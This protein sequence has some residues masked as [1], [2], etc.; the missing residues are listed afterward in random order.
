LLSGKT[1]SKPTSEK[2]LQELF[3][4]FY[5]RAKTSVKSPGEIVNSAK[6]S[7]GGLGSKLESRRQKLKDMKS[8]AM[9]GDMASKKEKTETPE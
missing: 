2:N 3:T 8:N 6:S 5:S 9:D 7:I 1:S 4:D